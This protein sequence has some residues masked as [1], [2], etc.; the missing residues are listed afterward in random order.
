M[1]KSFMKLMHKNQKGITGLETAIILIAF[2]VVAAVF[3]YTVLSAGLFATQKSQEA[4]YNGLSE[5]QSTLELRGSV[6]AYNSTLNEAVPGTPPGNS[7]G[8]VEFTVSSNGSDK[9]DLT[10]AYVITG[11]GPSANGTTLNR[12]QIA[13]NDNAVTIPNC[14]WTV[15]FIGK[16]N[17]DFILDQGE[18]AVITVWLHPYTTADDW[19]PGD[20]ADGY[21]GADNVD[22]YH[23][24]T[25]EVK[26]TTGATLAIERTTP[27][28]LDDVVD[29]H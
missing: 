21:I 10:P 23:T 29:L 4:V 2:V 28:L 24:F 6:V 25:L 15:A 3:A 13:F 14:V 16:N 5:T 22:T 11:G 18:K 12:L 20:T 19:S 17:S 9:I 1:I 26:P 8:K 7:V 27:A